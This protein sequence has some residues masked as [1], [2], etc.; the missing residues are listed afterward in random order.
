MF[1]PPYT[2]T[3][4]LHSGMPYFYMV[5][6]LCSSPSEFVICVCCVFRIQGNIGSG[7]FGSVSKGVWLF[8]GEGGEVVEG[9]GVQVAVK[10]VKTD[11]EEMQRVKLLQEAAIMGQFAHPNVVRLNGVV[12]VGDPVSNTYTHTHTHQYL[13]ADF[14]HTDN[15]CTGVHASWRPEELPP[16]NETSVSVCIMC[17]CVSSNCVCTEYQRDWSLEML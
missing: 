9:D 17:V 14:S 10:V 16:E 12:T 11:A 6:V 7:H 1:F 3:Y 5:R 2:T 8:R 15:D 4:F 13:N